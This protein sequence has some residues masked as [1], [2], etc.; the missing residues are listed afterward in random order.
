MFVVCYGVLVLDLLAVTGFVFDWQFKF[1]FSLCYLGCFEFCRS[2]T[3]VAL[4]DLLWLIIVGCLGLISWLVGCGLAWVWV[5]LM[6]VCCLVLVVICY[7]WLRGLCLLLI[8]FV[9]LIPCLLSLLV[10]FN[11][12]LLLGPL[13]GLGF[14]LAGCLW[15]CCFT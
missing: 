5:C 6:W 2:F 3:L 15:V 14:G 12:C 11:C 13:F 9:N 7:S 10:G 1:G 4:I 8:L